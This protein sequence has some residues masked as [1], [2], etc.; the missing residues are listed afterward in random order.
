MSQASKPGKKVDMVS[1]LQKK[2]QET[3]TAQVIILLL[4]IETTRR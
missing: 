3:K 2:E 4:F 1:S